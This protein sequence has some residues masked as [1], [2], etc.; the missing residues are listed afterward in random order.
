MEDQI[1]IGVFDGSDLIHLGLFKFDE[2]N[3]VTCSRWLCSS[4]KININLLAPL[5]DEDWKGRHKFKRNQLKWY[6]FIF[7]FDLEFNRYDVLLR[8]MHH[9]DR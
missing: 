4:E 8:G 7:S 9:I 1:T 3:Q 2:W 6:K 5:L